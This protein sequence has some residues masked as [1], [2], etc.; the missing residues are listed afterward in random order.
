[1]IDFRAF[2]WER[3]EPER[4]TVTPALVPCR[5]RLDSTDDDAMEPDEIDAKPP[6]FN[7]P[8]PLQSLIN[9]LVGSQD[10]I[11]SLVTTK[12]DIHRVSRS[13]STCSAAEIQTKLS[14]DKRC[15]SVNSSV[16]S[17]DGCDSGKDSE[18]VM[19][20]NNNSI[21]HEQDGIST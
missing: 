9:G 17:S 21:P 5:L 10:A 11:D 7:D 19:M 4:I 20:S 12:V 14:S 2:T 15:H 13:S 8:Q 6:K 1:L 18:Y 16:K 3:G